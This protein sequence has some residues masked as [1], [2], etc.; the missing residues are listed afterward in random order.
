MNLPLFVYGSM[1]D[2]EVRS[3]V[4]GRTPPAFRTEPAW[5]PGVAAAV[6]PGESYPY[7]V[8]VGGRARVRRADIRARR[9]VPRAH[10]VLRRRG[11]RV[12][13]MRS[14]AC[15]RRARRRDALRRGRRPGR[16]DHRL[17]APT[18]AGAG[19]VGVSLDDPRVHG[20][21]A[22]RDARAS[23]GG[24]AAACFASMSPAPTSGER[25]PIAIPHTTCRARLAHACNARSAVARSRRACASS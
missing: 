25:Q 13:R 8:S 17:V 3:L 15:R 10:S 23:R 11:V 6:V 7:L 14:R 18:V 21:L 24:L 1:R 9:A 22:P 2:V 16:A 20:T 5:M 12:R 19:E 4:L